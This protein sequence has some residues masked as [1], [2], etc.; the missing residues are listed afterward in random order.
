VLEGF[1]WI[2]LAFRDTALEADYRLDVQKRR[3]DVRKS[4]VSMIL[5]FTLFAM[6]AAS[7]ALIFSPQVADTIN[8]HFRLA[9]PL[10]LFG[11]TLTFWPLMTRHLQAYM[12]VMTLVIA[13]LLSM[14]LADGSGDSSLYLP[15]IYGLLIIWTFVVSGLGHIAAVVSSTLV[16]GFFTAVSYWFSDIPLDVYAFTLLWL[17]SVLTIG[18]IAAYLLELNSRRE[19]QHAE[20]SKR[21]NRKLTAVVET[22]VD[23]VVTVDAKGYITA[24]NT[25]AET[26]F[27]LSSEQVLGTGVDRILPSRYVEKTVEP[28]DQVRKDMERLAELGTVS[29]ATGIRADGSEFISELAISRWELDGEVFFTALVRDITARK[30][31]QFEITRRTLEARLLRRISDR[32][33]ETATVEETLTELVRLLCMEIEWPVGHAFLPDPEHDGRLIS[34]DIWYLVDEDVYQPFRDATQALVFAEGEGLPGRALASGEPEWI[35]DLQ[36]S[37]GRFYRAQPAFACKLHGALAIPVKG[38]G[39]TIAVLEFFSS[40][41][42][43]GDDDLQQ[44]MR[45]VGKQINRVLERSRGEQE[46]Q[47]ARQQAEL[48]NAAKS[49]FLAN[50]SHELR[51]PMN[52]ILGF[53]EMLM[54]E[55]EDEGQDGYIEDLKKIHDSGVHLMSLI[56]DVLDI[57]KI[58]TGTTDVKPQW[59]SVSELVEQVSATAGPLMSHNHNTFS[60]ICPE[61][62]G[63]VFQDTTK[64][65]QCLL[66]L[67]S[68][69]AKFTHDGS[70]ELRVRRGLES[71][72]GT[73]EW[74]SMTVTDSGIGIPEDKI[75]KVFEEFGQAD[76]STTRDYGGTGLGLPISRRFCRLLGGDLTPTSSPGEGS[77][78]NIRIPSMYLPVKMDKLTSQP[79]DPLVIADEN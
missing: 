21:A 3:V 68:N 15:G 40:H 36:T 44:I 35:E 69:A 12:F 71:G 41:R 17:A 22:A 59:F 33:S 70:I 16:L 42:L 34:S 30:Q 6:F 60:V 9:G 57:S 7:D 50:M 75:N 67:L 74:L 26:I 76:L 23:A 24:W 11:L 31:M 39:E 20:E 4:R 48:A 79:E 72:A 73:Q 55:A 64:V 19:Y 43:N 63:E 54:E 62:I 56:N 18:W 32:A 5:A 2:T 58:E 8:I 61:Q 27:G 13:M 66:N 53:S 51:T 14:I 45:N 1:N 49:A 29:E 46:L 28:L 65:R 77:T 10:L 38:D 47:V 52:A 78:F 25:S 37:R